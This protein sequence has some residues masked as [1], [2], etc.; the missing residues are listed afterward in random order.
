MMENN[1]FCTI[2]I[3]LIISML[4][5]VNCLSPSF[6]IIIITR[7]SLALLLRT[8]YSISLYYYFSSPLLLL[9]RCCS[10]YS[11]TPSTACAKV[12]G[13]CCWDSSSEQWPFAGCGLPKGPLKDMDITAQIAITI[14][15][16]YL[17]FFTAS[18][19][20]MYRDHI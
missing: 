14:C 16:S 20:V 17:V 6:I 2:D 18:E 9:H 4:H 1:A 19:M 7:S 10:P 13:Q 5:D 11:T 8:N 15:S 12:R 3:D